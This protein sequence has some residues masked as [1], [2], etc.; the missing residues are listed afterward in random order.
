MGQ[1]VSV[2]HGREPDARQSRSENSIRSGQTQNRGVHKHVENSR[3]YSTLVHLKLAQRRRLQFYQTRSHTITLFKN[4][5]RFVYDLN[6]KVHQCPR[7][8]RVVLAPNTQHVRILPMPKRENPPTIIKANKASGT[9]KPAAYFSRTH[10][11]KHPGESQRWKTRIATNRQIHSAKVERVDHWQ[12]VVLRAL[13][14]F[15]K[16]TIP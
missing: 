8:P 7:L 12:H 10:V 4:Y 6:C 11:A 14:D 15:F 5:L 16:D 1:A 9:E 13:R 3:K 2:F